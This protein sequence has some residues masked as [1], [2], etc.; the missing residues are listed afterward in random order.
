MFMVLDL[1]LGGDLRFH[2]MRVGILPEQTTRVYAAECASAISYLHANQIIHRDL[3]PENLLL[4]G[5]G[6]IHITDFNVAIMLNEKIPSSRSGT[7]SYMG[8]I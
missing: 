2:L 3:K 6:H 8:S 4:D 7:T 5:E 1:A